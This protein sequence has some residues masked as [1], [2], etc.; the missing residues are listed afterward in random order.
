MGSAGEGAVRR[1]DQGLVRK[2]WTPGHK[3]YVYLL[4]RRIVYPNIIQAANLLGTQFS[5][6]RASGRMSKAQI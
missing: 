6:A 4:E 3:V 5:Q 2:V 1:E